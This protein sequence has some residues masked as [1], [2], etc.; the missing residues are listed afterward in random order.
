VNPEMY[1]HC[2]KGMRT[3]DDS[4]AIEFVSSGVDQGWSGGGPWSA[5]TPQQVAAAGEA[6]PSGATVPLSIY[7]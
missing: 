4:R 7:L 2:I 6:R 3:I 5:S 1:K